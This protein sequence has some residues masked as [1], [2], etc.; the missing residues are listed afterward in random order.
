MTQSQRLESFTSF[1][2]SKDP[3]LHDK[4]R[5]LAINEEGSV[6]SLAQ[7]GVHYTDQDWDSLMNL[8]KQ[9]D[10]DQEA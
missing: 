9:F 6:F 4:V 7:L 5:Q 2:L 8:L 1:L 3:E 10:L